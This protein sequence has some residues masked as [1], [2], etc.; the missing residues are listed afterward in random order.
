MEGYFTIN[1]SIYHHHH[2]HHHHHHGGKH[3]YH[4]HSFIQSF[5][6]IYSHSYAL[7][8]YAVD[9]GFTRPLVPFDC[10]KMGGCGP[11]TKRVPK[12]SCA[13]DINNMNPKYVWE[14]PGHQ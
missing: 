8:V 3:N 13:I 11:G 1:E 5:T 7:V 2:H 12:K 10:D 9:L 6:V 4:S 14:W